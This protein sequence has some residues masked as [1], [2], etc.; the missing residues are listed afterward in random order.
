MHKVARGVSVRAMLPQAQQV[1]V[2]DSNTGNVAA[3]GERVDPEGLFIAEIPGRSEL[4]RY[5][6]RVA[7][8]VMTREFDDIYRFSPVLGELDLYLLA[9]GNHLASY[10]KPAPIRSLHEGVEGVAFAVWAPNA[11]AIS[12]VGDFSAWDGRRMPMRRR[13]AT[14]FWELFVPG[15]RAGHLYKYE[16]HG[17]QG[18]LLPLKADPHAERAERPPKTA[19]V[20][21]DAPGHFWQDGAWMAE[22]WQANDRET[23]I[24]IYE[25]HLGSWRRRIED[26][27]YLTYRELIAELVPYV[28]EM[29]FTHI[30]LMPIMEYPF[31][32]SWGYQPISLFAPTSRYGQPDDFRALVEACHQAGIG[33]LLDWVPGHFPNDPHGLGRFDGTALSNMPI[34]V[35]ASTVTGTR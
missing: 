34:P 13:G 28:A 14:G 17:P 9:E 2:I 26:N 30:E 5:K 16:I 21:A 4:F 27:R 31:D 33:V 3:E 18:Q 1:A 24:A 8:G 32:G 22:R 6:L 29:G 12:L 7:D 19:S 10:K 20:V 23:P 25:V 11:S 35:R 15:L